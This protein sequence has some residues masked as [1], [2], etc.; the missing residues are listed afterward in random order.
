MSHILTELQMESIKIH[1]QYELN[2]LSTVY[3][4]GNSCL[5]S[6]VPL[7][8]LMT[9]QSP[10]HMVSKVLEEAIEACWFIY[11]DSYRMSARTVCDSAS[12]GSVSSTVVSQQ[13]GTGAGLGVL[14]LYD[15]LYQPLPPVILQ[16][17]DALGLCVHSLCTHC[18]SLSSDNGS[19]PHSTNTNAP[20]DANN[21]ND[22]MNNRRTGSVTAATASGTDKSSIAKTDDSNSKLESTADI[23]SSIRMSILMKLLADVDPL[24]ENNSGSSTGSGNAKSSGIANTPILSSFDATT[25]IKNRGGHSSSGGAGTHTMQSAFTSLGLG[26]GAGMWD[27]DDKSSLT[28][29]EAECRR[30][31]DFY[32]AFSLAV[33]ISSCQNNT[34]K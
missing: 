20:T 21:E 9:A 32:L 11:V 12:G 22:S 28:P 34:Q 25:S 33:L 5:L 8:A 2:R 14:T 24:V 10:A 13:S 17:A 1:C 23:E 30:A 27:K 16:L 29:T 26:L 3:Q 31:E 19:A 4:P 7:V 18:A 6:A 15:L